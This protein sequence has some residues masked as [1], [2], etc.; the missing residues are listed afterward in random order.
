MAKTVVLI[1]TLDTKGPEIAYLRDRL[2][3]LG[4]STIVIAA[5]SAS[6]WKSCRTF[7]TNNQQPTRAPTWKPCVPQEVVEKPLT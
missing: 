6:H 3:E 2:Q 1:G 7:H 5:F 4:L